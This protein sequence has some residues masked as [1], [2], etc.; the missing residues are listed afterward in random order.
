[1]VKVRSQ[2]A[3]PSTMRWPFVQNLMRMYRHQMVRGSVRGSIPDMGCRLAHF[4]RDGIL[5]R[6]QSF[7]CNRCLRVDVSF[8]FRQ[9]LEELIDAMRLQFELVVDLGGLVLHQLA[10]TRRDGLRRQ[11]EPRF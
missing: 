4:D 1:M 5:G 2:T 11:F 7:R 10:D 6:R 8:Y 9:C 3:W